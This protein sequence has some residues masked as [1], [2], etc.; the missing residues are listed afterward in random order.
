M[1]RQMETP[2]PR[3]PDWQRWLL[4][5]FGTLLTVVGVV[6]IW[7]PFTSLLLVIGIPMMFCF[8][9]HYENAARARFRRVLIG[10]HRWIPRRLRR[11]RS[12]S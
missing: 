7:L 1:E 8:S 4:P 6:F 11:R 9:R 10:V 5:I 3:R 12:R 2:A